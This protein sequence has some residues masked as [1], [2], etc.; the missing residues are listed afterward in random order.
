MT[1]HEGISL[2]Q[3]ERRNDEVFSPFVIRLPR[4]SRA[5]ASHS[6]F[7][8]A[9]AFTILELLIVI[10]I[11]IILAG[12]TIATMGY[13]QGKARRS[14]A[15]AEIAAISAA[16]ENYK[17]DNGIYPKSADTDTLD[18]TSAVDPTTSGFSKASLYLYEQLSGDT[19]ADRKTDA[20]SYMAFK[21][22]QL[23]PTDQ[24]KN[25]TAI[26]DPFGKSYGYSTAKFN[27]G[28][29]YNPTFDLWSTANGTKSADVPGW[30]KNW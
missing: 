22:N 24:T 5:K 4:R 25:V 3:Q 27:G 28:K 20:K 16:L 19:D 30:V 15:E 8:E 9:A 11:I 18:P 26:V 23:S 1:K 2:G 29:G 14:R 7:R 10:T 12:L 13:V 6:S 21:P 17:A